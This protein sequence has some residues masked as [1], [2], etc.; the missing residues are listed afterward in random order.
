MAGTVAA[1]S[2]API[3]PTAVMSAAAARAAA[4]GTGTRLIPSW[5]AE[6]VVAPASVGASAAMANREEAERQQV[7]PER[8]PTARTPCLGSLA[9]RVQGR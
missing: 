2:A 6:T 3:Q 7:H 9:R 1:A 4:A 8:Q 5:N